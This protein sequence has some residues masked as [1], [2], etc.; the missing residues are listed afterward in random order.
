MFQARLLRSRRE[1]ELSAEA[2]SVLEHRAAPADEP[3]R[4][5]QARPLG[6]RREEELSAEAD[7]V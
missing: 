3:W 7:L 2:E 1:E 5:F 6:S 4:M